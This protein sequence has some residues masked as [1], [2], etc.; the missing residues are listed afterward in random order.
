MA[1]LNA[2][3]HRFCDDIYLSAFTARDELIATA[4]KYRKKTKQPVLNITNSHDWHEVEQSVQDACS[5]LEALAT[6]DKDMSGSLGRVKRA[7][8]NLCRNAGAGQTAAALIPN[9]SFGFTSV[10]CGSL[11]VVFSGLRTTGTYRQEVYRTLE[12]LPIRLKD[13]AADV[14]SYDRDEEIHRRA[15]ALYAAT[16]QLLNHILHWFLKNSFCQCNNML[17]SATY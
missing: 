14:E 5:G 13:L 7:Y 1:R 9:D 3:N 12:D 10:L 15:A 17:T 16:F 4:N 2:D 8:R 11:K 6:K